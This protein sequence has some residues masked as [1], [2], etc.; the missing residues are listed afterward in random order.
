M[1][2]IVRIALRI[3]IM[4]CVISLIMNHYMYITGIYDI[5]AFI[6]YFLGI[7]CLLIVFFILKVLCEN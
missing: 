7:T 5:Y 6:G 4:L 1:Q 3:I 2:K